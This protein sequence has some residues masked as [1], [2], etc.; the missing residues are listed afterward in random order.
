MTTNK[1]TIEAGAAIGGVTGGLPGALIGAAVGSMFGVGA[2][3]SYVPSTKS[4][5]AGPTVVFAPGFIGGGAGYSFSRLSVPSS[6]N[7][8]SVASGWGLTA[9]F[10]PLPFAGSTVLKSPGNG[11]AVIGPSV[12]SRAPVSFGAGYNFTLREGG[13]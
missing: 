11:P 1:L 13:C 9:T 4:I 2:N 5:Y 7:P 8:N 12:G 3:V 6:Q 10:Q